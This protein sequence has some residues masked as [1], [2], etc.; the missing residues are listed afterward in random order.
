MFQFQDRVKRQLLR[1]G[2]LVCRTG[3]CSFLVLVSAVK[4]KEREVFHSDL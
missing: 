4:L 3:L 1:C 2:E